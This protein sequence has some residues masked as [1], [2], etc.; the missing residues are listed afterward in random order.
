MINYIFISLLYF[1]DFAIKTLGCY[2]KRVSQTVLHLALNE[3]KNFSPGSLILLEYFPCS[4][5][6][7]AMKG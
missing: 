5:V 6:T 3:F 7:T 1:Y 4:R 2:F